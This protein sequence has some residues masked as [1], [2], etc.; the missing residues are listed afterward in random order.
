MSSCFFMGTYVYRVQ[1]YIIILRAVT[2]C[3][4]VEQYAQPPECVIYP[5]AVG[6]TFGVT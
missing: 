3:L 2:T 1:G 6:H 4:W 5:D